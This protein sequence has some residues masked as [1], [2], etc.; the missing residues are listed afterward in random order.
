M[1]CPKQSECPMSE[2]YGIPDFDPTEAIEGY[3]SSPI[4]VIGINQKTTPERHISGKPSPTTW[5]DTDPD[6]PHFRRLKQV[7]GDEWY[8]HLF[9]LGGI[10]HTDLLKCG[11]PGYTKVEISSVPHCRDFLIE[12][13]CKYKPKLLL[14]V[15]SAASRFISETAM[16]NGKTEGVWKYK[17]DEECFVVFSGYTGPRQD[18]FAKYRLNKD[19]LAACARLNLCPPNHTIEKRS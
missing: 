2:N 18:R 11:S 16:L 9:K 10:A 17:S 12:Q 8:P 6:A 19:F 4:W 1:S 5:K 7:L 3:A 15:S 14:I 13:V